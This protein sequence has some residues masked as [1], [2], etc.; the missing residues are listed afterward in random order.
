MI[1]ETVARGQQGDS[2]AFAALYQEHKSRVYST[3]LRLVHDRDLAEDLTQDVFLQVLK[4]LPSFRGTAQFKTWLWTV[5]WNMTLMAIRKQKREWARTISLEVDTDDPEES[6]TQDLAMRDGHLESTPLRLELE[7]A[8]PLLPP[9]QQQIFRMHYIGGFECHEIAAMIG[10]TVG[11]VKSTCFRARVN[12]RKL[13]KIRV[14]RPRL[15][16]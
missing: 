10:C 5:A 2:E 14:R 15:P 11:T 7:E 6:H 1:T 16:Q 12:L 13:L 8:I 9:G 4:T 3:C